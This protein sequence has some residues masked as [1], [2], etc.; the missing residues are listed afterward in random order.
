LNTTWINTKNINFIF[1][2]CAIK[3]C[4][5]TINIQIDHFYNVQRKFLN[6]I[7]FLKDSR[8]KLKSWKV[9]FSLQKIKQLPFCNKHYRLLDN[10][11]FD[12]SQ[13]ENMCM[14]YKKEI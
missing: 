9:I 2:T 12:K 4:D 1:K 11:N 7:I 6:G 10:E 13:L 14:I 3:R 8:K 5:N